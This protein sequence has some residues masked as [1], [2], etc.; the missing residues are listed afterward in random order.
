MMAY[1][2]TPRSLIFIFIVSIFASLLCVN[3]TTH[4]VWQGLATLMNVI[5][6][7]LL[8]CQGIFEIVP[9]KF[10]G[11][12]GDLI[13]HQ[14]LKSPFLSN[15][16]FMAFW[17]MIIYTDTLHWSDIFTKAWPC[18][19]IGPYYLFDVITLFREVTIGHLQRVQLVNRGYYIVTRP[20]T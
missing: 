10:C 6:W 7:E 8:I 2:I 16:S 13:K 15:K 9:K 17:D 11:C 14:T 5:F 12:Y 19:R 20:D 1:Q 18:Y 4:K 3:L